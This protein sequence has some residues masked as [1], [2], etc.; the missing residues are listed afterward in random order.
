MLIVLSS[1][2]SRTVADVAAFA[3]FVAY[4]DLAGRKPGMELLPL[5]LVVSLRP[6]SG[7][8]AASPK[9]LRAPASG[10]AWAVAAWV[11]QMQRAGGSRRAPPGP[12][13]HILC[14]K[15]YKS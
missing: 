2:I 15:Q 1:L 8:M 10:S 7:S 3:V 5:W 9:D 14:G 6:G 11:P 12:S 13:W 4:G